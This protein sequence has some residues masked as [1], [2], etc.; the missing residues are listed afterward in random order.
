M[1]RHTAHTHTHYFALKIK[2]MTY[3]MYISFLEINEMKI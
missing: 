2:K 3:Q 1:A